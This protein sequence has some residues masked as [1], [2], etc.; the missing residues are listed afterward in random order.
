MADSPF[1]NFCDRSEN[2]TRMHR[3]LMPFVRNV[4]RERAKGS[5]VM[6]GQMAQK[7]LTSLPSSQRDG[8][9]HERGRIFGSIRRR[10]PQCEYC[11]C[12]SGWL[13]N[14]G[15]KLHLSGP[16]LLGLI[17]RVHGADI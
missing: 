6:R 17:R 4:I 9:F 12:F 16:S 14:L 7:A 11:T 5:S 8:A 2:A 10:I 1:K 3:R 15:E 13:P